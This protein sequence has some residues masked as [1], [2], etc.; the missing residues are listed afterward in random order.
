MKFI[1]LA[2]TNAQ[3][4][5][6][7]TWDP[8]EFQQACDFYEQ[9]G[10]D[11]AESGEGVYTAGLGDPSLTRTIRD[12]PTGTVAADG[13]Y[14][15]VKEVL[16]S[17]GIVDVVSADRAYEIAHRIV[18]AVGDIVEVRPLMDGSADS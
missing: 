10:K 5:V 1:M 11:L 18:D 16:A 9:L 13:P 17:F 14:A 2:Y 4:W 7:G 6:E 3:T 8:E 15:E 12:T